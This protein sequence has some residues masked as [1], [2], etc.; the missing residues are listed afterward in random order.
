METKN[1]IF[2]IL[3][4]ILII[5]SIIFSVIPKELL[6]CADNKNK[7]KIQ[8]SKYFY[9]GFSI[10]G[11]ILII[12]LIILLSKVIK[13]KVSNLVFGIVITFLVLLIFGQVSLTIFYNIEDLFKKI[14]NKFKSGFSKV[15]E[16]SRESRI[17]K[18]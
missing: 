8:C 11:A 15:E 4:I 3:L 16:S 6:L 13:N 5:G 10:L 17:A 14:I 18:L 1:I 9:G 7:D 2:I 12:I